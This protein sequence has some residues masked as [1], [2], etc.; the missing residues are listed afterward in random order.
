MPSPVKS[1]QQL[2]V[3]KIQKFLLYEIYILVRTQQRNTINKKNLNHVRRL[4]GKIKHRKKGA[5]N[6]R[7]R[8]REFKFKFILKYSS[9][10]RCCWTMTWGMEGENWWQ[11]SVSGPGTEKKRRHRWNYILV[12]FEDIK[13]FIVVWMESKME[14][15]IRVRKVM[16]SH[17]CGLW[18]PPC[19]LWLIFSKW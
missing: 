12:M 8:Q 14:T 4:W 9:L 13:E 6:T 19:E 2:L 5:Q 16:R 11:N 10:E 15:I 18:R 7:W 17:S 3:I 1:T